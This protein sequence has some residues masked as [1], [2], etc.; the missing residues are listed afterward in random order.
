MVLHNNFADFVLF[1]Y[2]HM[3]HSDGDYHATEIEVIRDKMA[4]IFP[5]DIDHEQKL[6]EAVEQY[7][8]LNLA[9]INA[10]IQDS[11]K[12]FDK[13]KFTQKYKVYTD[14]Y[15]IINAD[16]VID[17]SETKALSELKKIIDINSTAEKSA[18]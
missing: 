1:L 8:S 5:K 18:V 17:E 13:V 16:G 14:M 10:A 4:K 9:N 7:K 2:V 11:F 12:H 6:K 3:A 15:D